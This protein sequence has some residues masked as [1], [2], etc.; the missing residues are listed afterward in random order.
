MRHF[1]MVWLVCPRLD[2]EPRSLFHPGG[3]VGHR[4]LACPPMLVLSP[5]INNNKTKLTPNST[6]LSQK[7]MASSH[8]DQ[9]LSAS[10]YSIWMPFNRVRLNFRVVFVNYQNFLPIDT[11]FFFPTCIH[12]S[13]PSLSF[14]PSFLNCTISYTPFISFFL[15]TLFPSVL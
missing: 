12:P 2:V 3:T 13:I 9:V 4:H 8:R 7:H 14:L 6:T 5:P 10:T 1:C 15:T 11:L